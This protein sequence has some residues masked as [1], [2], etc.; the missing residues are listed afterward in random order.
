MRFKLHGLRTKCALMLPICLLAGVC[1]AQIE[2]KRIKTGEGPDVEELNRV[3]AERAEVMIGMRD[4]QDVIN[5]AVNYPTYDTPAITKLR[6]EIE[7]QELKLHELRTRLRMEVVALKQV[8]KLVELQK[9]DQKKLQAL[10]TKR[11][12]LS[13]PAA[14]GGKDTD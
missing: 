8:K 14:G 11:D 3:A 1:A 12:A 4:R 2:I 5:R 7:K 10:T 6:E 9:A 13:V